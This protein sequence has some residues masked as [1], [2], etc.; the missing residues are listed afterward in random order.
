MTTVVNHRSHIKVVK[1]AL[2]YDSLTLR[3]F[4]QTVVWNY[5][6]LREHFSNFPMFFKLVKEKKNSCLW[7]RGSGGNLENDQ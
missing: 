5:R 7:P 3:D 1:Y 2:V 4:I 6:T